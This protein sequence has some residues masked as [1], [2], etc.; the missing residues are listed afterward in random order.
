MKRVREVVKRTGLSVS[1]YVLG[2]LVLMLAVAYGF[3]QASH[4]REV[5]VWRDCVLTNSSNKTVSNAILGFSAVLVGASQDDGEPQDAR[6]RAR[7]ETFRLGVLDLV[8]P[9]APQDCGPRP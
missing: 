2:Y 5:I 6:Q 7:L 8:K 4:D 9:L 1:L 3:N